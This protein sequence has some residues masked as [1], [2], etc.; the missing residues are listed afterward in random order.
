M[1]GYKTLERILQQQKGNYGCCSIIVELF[2]RYL[3]H[4]LTTNIVTRQM[5][6]V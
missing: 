3:F 5:A 2:T 6:I 4:F 1:Y